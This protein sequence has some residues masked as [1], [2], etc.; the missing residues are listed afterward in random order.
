MRRPMLVTDRV[1]EPAVSSPSYFFAIV[2]LR[3]DCTVGYT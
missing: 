3:I 2:T 1:N